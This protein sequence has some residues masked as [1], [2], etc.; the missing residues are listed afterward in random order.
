MIEDRNIGELYIPASVKHFTF[1]GVQ[2]TI[3]I[4]DGG[5]VYYAGTMEQWKRLADDNAD[6]YSSVTVDTSGTV[7]LTIVCTNGELSDWE[8]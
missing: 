5:R 6:R 1:H 7:N 3:N 4:K 8:D 2:Y